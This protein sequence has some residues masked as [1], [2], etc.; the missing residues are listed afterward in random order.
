M[1]EENYK[2]RTN[3]MFLR[4][5]FGM[6]MPILKKISLQDDEKEDL[7]LIG[8]DIAKTET[9]THFNRFVHFFLYDYKFEDIWNNPDKYIE[10]LSQ[11]KAVLTPDFS[12]YIEMNEN[13]QRYNTFRNRWVGAHTWQIKVFGLSQQLTGNLKTLS[14]SA[15][16]VLKK[17]AQLQYR[18]IWQAHT[19]TEPTKKIFLWLATMKC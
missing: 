9:D 12:M 7:R 3:P 14:I 15:L 1:T 18:L 4:N 5:Q 13:M 6:D 11:Y 17:E 16:M 8:F 2:Y 19:E 10:K